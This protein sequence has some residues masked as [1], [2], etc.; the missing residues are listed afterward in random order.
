MRVQFDGQRAQSLKALPRSLEEV[1]VMA[2]F[3]GLP[4]GGDEGVE[5]LWVADA[6]LAPQL[7][8]GW[9]EH[10]DPDDKET[11]FYQNVWTGEMMWEH[12]QISFLRG[13][14]GAINHAVRMKKAASP[15][16]N[17]ILAVRAVERLAP[18]DAAPIEPSRPTTPVSSTPNKSPEPVH[19]SPGPSPLRS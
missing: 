18:F 2:A 5:H 17:E 7:P 9:Y 12:P 10:A 3:L 15:A 11:K 13:A 4:Y 6:A 1:L 19:P 8:L 16:A 14:V